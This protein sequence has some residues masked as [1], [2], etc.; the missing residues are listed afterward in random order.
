MP[1][2]HSYPG[3]CHCRNLEVRLDSDLSPIELG[4]R[5]DGC[6]FCEKHQALYT[7]DPAGEI[8]LSGREAHLVQRYRFG[9]RSADFLLCKGCGILV[10]VYLP[11][12]GL[13]VVNVNVLDARAAFLAH[14]IS[15]ADFE[16]ESLEHRLARR[17]ARWTPVV[18]FDVP[19]T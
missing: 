10:A 12:P 3:A 16:G 5:A 13:A 7:S 6:S 8:H 14:P 2:R 9:T 1:R 17:R 11:S 18:S 19:S 15:R 4:V